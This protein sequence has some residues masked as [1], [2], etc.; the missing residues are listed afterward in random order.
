MKESYRKGVA[1]RP[2]LEPC[3]GVLIPVPIEKETVL[4]MTVVL[5]WRP[6]LK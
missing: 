6:A 2:D 5:N 1:N 3:E 4:P